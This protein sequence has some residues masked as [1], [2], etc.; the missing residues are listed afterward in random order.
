MVAGLDTVVADQA[1]IPHAGLF[2]VLTR[3]QN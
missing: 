3:Q 2:E 1:A